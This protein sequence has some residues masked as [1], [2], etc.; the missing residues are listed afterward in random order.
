[1]KESKVVSRAA[2]EMIGGEEREGER[3]FS[4]F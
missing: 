3:D 4:R 2:R 1:V